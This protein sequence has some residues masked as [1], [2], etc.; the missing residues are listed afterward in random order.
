MKSQDQI[1]EVLPEADNV[2]KDVVQV[3]YYYYIKK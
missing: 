2:L 3:E 1:Y